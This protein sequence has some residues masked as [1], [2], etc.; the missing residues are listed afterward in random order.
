MTVFCLELL[1][2]ILGIV[3]LKCLLKT[4]LLDLFS[5]LNFRFNHHL[6][7]SGPQGF[8]YLKYIGCLEKTLM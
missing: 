7:N 2:G 6:P 1:I 8:E 4:L 3:L 5:V